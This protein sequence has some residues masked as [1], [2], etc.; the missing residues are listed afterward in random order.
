MKTW[1]LGFMALVLSTV[2]PLTIAVAEELTGIYHEARMKEQ[3]YLEIDGGQVPTIPLG[4]S[5]RGATNG[6][7][8]WVSGD[9]KTALYG[10]P[11]KSDDSNQQAPTQWQVFMIVKEW[12]AISKPFERPAKTKAQNKQVDAVRP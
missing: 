10:N 6:M 2:L 8:V 4:D 5:L 3:P 1:G 11:D 12:K 9:I 7:R